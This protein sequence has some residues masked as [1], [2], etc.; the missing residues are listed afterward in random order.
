MA[1]RKIPSDAGKDGRVYAHLGALDPKGTLQIIMV[2]DSQTPEYCM[3]KDG[4]LRR[5]VFGSGADHA[6]SY[7]RVILPK[8]AILV[9][10][11]PSPICINDSEGRTAVTFRKRNLATAEIP[12]MAY[13]WTEK[14][15]VTM[16]SLPPEYRGLRDPRDVQLAEFYQRQIAAIL[17]GADYRDQSNPVA[18]L[19]TWRCAVVKEDKDLCRESQYGFPKFFAGTKFPDGPD[20]AANTKSYFIDSMTFLSTPAWP[21]HPTE[22]YMHPV[23]MCYPGTLLRCDTHAVIFHDGKWRVIGNTGNWRDTDVSVFEKYR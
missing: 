15:G 7:N 1:G 12:V 17:A 18:A 20:R 14:D 13:L 6:V 19:L 5:C 3:Q 22:G 9:C 2:A 8:S 23:Y 16:E 11:W 4:N 10:A 21:D